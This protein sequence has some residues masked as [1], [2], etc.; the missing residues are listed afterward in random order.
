[1]LAKI[2]FKVT[3]IIYYCKYEVMAFNP[4]HVD[5][6]LHILF[7]STSHFV[8]KQQTVLTVDRW[9]DFFHRALKHQIN[10][11]QKGQCPYAYISCEVCKRLLQFGSESQDNTVTSL[12][13]VFQITI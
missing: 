1:M 8:E 10:S 7:F 12:K 4:L 3:Y 11:N 13:C 5:F 9:Q 2:L 6:Y